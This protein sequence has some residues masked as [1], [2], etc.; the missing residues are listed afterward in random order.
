MN[1]TLRNYS[2]A[3]W[4]VLSP[5]ATAD[6]CRVHRTIILILGTL[7]TNNALKVIL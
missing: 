1:N 7:E 3:Y 6:I 4:T 5:Y 2:E